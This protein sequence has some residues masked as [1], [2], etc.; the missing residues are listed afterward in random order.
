MRPIVAALLFLCSASALAQAGNEVRQLERGNGPEPSTLD[1][2]R[3]QEVACGNV[4]RDLYEGLVTEDAAGRL[5]PGMAERWEVSADGR[6]WTFHLRDG[7]RWSNGAPLDAAQVVASFRRAFSPQTAAP[8]AELFD[9]LQNAQ[10]VQAGQLPPASLGV[11]APDPRRV[12]FTLSRSAALPALLTLPIAFPVYLPAVQ[13]FGAQH[14]RPGRL[15]GNGAYSLLA[16]TPQA[17]L[18]VQKNPHFHAAADV[19]IARVRYQV[20]EDASAELQR[21]A[22]GDLHI[23]ETVP[24]QPLQALRERFGGRLRIAPYL[25]AFWLGLNLTRPP[26]KDAPALREALSLAVDRDKLTR[27]VTGLGEQPAYGLV[28]TGIPGYAGAQT[29]W[30]RASQAQREARAKALYRAAGYS[31]GKPL[32]LELRYNTSTPHRRMALAVASMWRDVL[33]VQVRLRNE[34]WKVFVQN[35]KQRTITQVF[36]GGWVGDVV[37]AR[38]F[39]AAFG[40][41]GP[42]NWT[43]YDD[44]GFRERLARADA[45]KTEAARNAWLHAAEQ[46]LLNDH[47]AIP[48]YFY[49]SKHLVG[50]ELEGFEANPLDRHASRWLRWRH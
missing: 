6:T 28:P 27:H 16:W 19:S 10:A 48:L 35:R 14:T 1:A 23:T 36:R 40:S 26:F 15:V 33:G 17:N 50:P 9:A 22:A 25:G 11:A 24:P 46:T 43:G 37:D 8:F 2:H 39:I 42:L 49:T 30:A 7:L 34:E 38:N 3:C 29:T 41:D 4:L 20:T 45:A 12:V 13:R 44:A 32:V 18:S 31:E 21:F 47:M 5:I